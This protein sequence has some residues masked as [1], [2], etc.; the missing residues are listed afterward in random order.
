VLEDFAK[1][2]TCFSASAVFADAQHRSG[3]MYSGI[4]PID[5]TLVMVGR[6]LTVQLSAGDL[7]D[8]L[9]AIDIVGQGDIVVVDAGG[10]TETAVW[11]GLMGSLCKLR[12]A[13]GAVIDGACR[14]ADENRAHGFQVFSRSIT[15]RGT[16]TMISG[17]TDNVR[18]QVPVT[19]GGVLVRPGDVLV[20]DELGVTVVAAEEAESVLRLAREQAEREEATRR[21]IA[22]GLTVDELLSEFGRL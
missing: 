8:P 5:R 13:A 4:K 12:G 22:D 7:Q 14:D 21:R 9:A 10:D 19:C 6:A 18:L 1:V 17:R 20:G 16:H 2:A 11:G 15:P 3:V